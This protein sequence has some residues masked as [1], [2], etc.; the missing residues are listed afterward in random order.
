MLIRCTIFIRCAA[1]VF[2]V[3]LL[4]GIVA[5]QSA[6]LPAAA[7]QSPSAAET[8]ADSNWGELTLFNGRDFDGLH[9]FVQDAVMKAADVVRV[10][11]GAIRVSGVGKGYIRTTAAYADF[12]LSLEWRWPKGGG[13]SGVLLHMVNPDV[14]WPKGFEVQLA[15]GR[16]GDL[17]SYADARSKE[18]LVSRNPTGFSTGRL[19]RKAPADADGSVTEKTA[20]E[21]PLGEWNR[22]EVLALGDELTVWINGALVNRMTGVI[23]S[24]GMIGLQAEGTAIDFRNVTLTPLPPRKDLHAPMPKP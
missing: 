13:N 20:I 23:P 22:L 18:E 1:S 2:L 17:S 7:P 14:I 19:A 3:A 11:D 24:A 21:K 4:V 6:A 12:K 15:T 8:P 9:I 16:A 5:A 10:E